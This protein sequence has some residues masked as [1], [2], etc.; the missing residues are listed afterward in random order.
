MLPLFISSL[1]LSKTAAGLL[2][3][4]LTAPS[5][6]QPFIGHLA[7]RVS[8]RYFV[9]L[10][11]CVTAIMMSLLGVAPDY[12][13]LVLLLLVAGFSSAS[14][15]AVGP[16]MVGRLAGPNLGRGMG[17]WMVGGEL[18][19]T[20]GPIIIVTML[21]LIGQRGTPLLLVGGLLISALLFIRLR[22]VPAHDTDA[23]S[24]L[25]WRAILSVMGPVMLP[26]SGVVLARA[27]I[28]SSLTTYLPTYLSER[29]ASIWFAGAALTILEAAG[30]GGALVGGS[31]SDWFGRRRVLFLSLAITPP[32]MLAFHG[33]EGW[34]RI[35]LLVLMGCAALAVTP[36][37]MALVQEQFPRNRA[38]ANGIYM[39]LSFS[40]RALVIAILG[41]FG[42]R[43]GM[44]ATFLISAAVGLA[45]VPLVLLLPASRGPADGVDPP[46]APTATG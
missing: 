22:D 2:A 9:I 16:A 5:L 34:A 27:F 26:L 28:L 6:V 20:L 11:P 14:I 25:P 30:V 21:R 44:D 39:A 36:I 29:G 35:P 10:A 7:D 12:E 8:L 23:I 18:G 13:T 32:L 19:R 17:I 1:A 46:V 37:V 15:H 33:V 38:L 45:G 31:L 24:G 3:V 42:D 4:F 41:G 43:F 40:L